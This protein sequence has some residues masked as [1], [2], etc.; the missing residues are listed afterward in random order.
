MLALT[1]EQQEASGAREVMAVNFVTVV[2][3][4]DKDAGTVLQTWRFADLPVTF[5]SD[6]YES[7]LI[8]VTPQTDSMVHL[9]RLESAGSDGVPGRTLRAVIHRGDIDGTLLYEDMRGQNLESASVEWFQV[10]VP[11]GGQGADVPPL[12]NIQSVQAAVAAMVIGDRVVR[13][14]GDFED[15][16]VTDKGIE[17]TA[18]AARPAIPWIIASDAT[19]VDP[20]DV[21]RRL[22]FVYGKMGKVR[23]VGWDVGAASTL[24]TLIDED[25]TTI[26]VTDG[27]RFPTSGSGLI[28]TESVSWTGR[29]A[30]SLTTVTRGAD[31]TTAVSHALGEV[32]VE[33]IATA[34]WIVNAR[35]SDAFGDLFVV[36]PYNGAVVRV[37]ASLYTSTLADTT[38]ISGETV[39]SVKFTA[40]NLRALLID[41]A[42]KGTLGEGALATE[43]RFPDAY[44]NTPAAQDHYSWLDG[45]IQTGRT[46]NTI[47]RRLRFEES[48]PRAD[49]V[50]EKCTYRFH[51]SL[52]NTATI[53]LRETSGGAVLETITNSFG[54]THQA[55]WEI[56]TTDAGLLG[57]ELWITTSVGTVTILAVSRIEHFAG[58]FPFEWVKPKA[59]AS[60]MGTFGHF[61]DGETAVGGVTTLTT[62]GSTRVFTI[63]YDTDTGDPPEEIR[64][65]VYAKLNAGTSTA[66]EVRI[67]GSGDAL[68]TWIGRS[69]N[70]GG[71]IEGFFE[72]VITSDNDSGELAS[73]VI[74]VQLQ[75]GNAGTSS[76]VTEVERW[77]LRPALTSSAE[78]A[79][80]TVGIGLVLFADLDGIVAAGGNYIAADGVVLE[81]MPDILRHV[82]ADLA[83]EGQTAISANW[84]DAASATNLDDN[85]HALVLNTLGASFEEIVERAAFDSRANIGVTHGSAATPLR[86]WEMLAAESD[87]TWDPPG[88]GAVSRTI[89][90]YRNV[91]EKLRP[92]FEV[93]TRFRALYNWDAS[94]GDG[95]EAFDS[96]VRIDTDQ[97]DTHGST[98]GPSN[99]EIATAETI[100][101]RRDAPAVLFPTIRDELTAEEVL[102][103]YAKERIREGVR[104]FS[105]F[106]V[107]WIEAYDLEQGDV[108]LLEVDWLDPVE[109]PNGARL[110]IV[111][112]D[113]DPSTN[114]FDVYG[115]EVS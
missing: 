21:G 84:D 46:S 63:T 103:Y 69:K 49:R 41:I 6:A 70:T 97:A 1:A 18:R 40:A 76:N 56:E 29:T 61:T 73:D 47:N 89:S 22:P 114:T 90:R 15:W 99:T 52:T 32:L 91:T 39:T 88:G 9:P 85:V 64:Y 101:G 75:N 19:Q 38:T 43:E 95:P 44:P 71:A 109:D 113:K 24:S 68:G 3:Y 81:K 8:D 10:L 57:S 33:T 74:Q 12:E 100:Y 77:E 50:I 17:I 36:S 51:A 94:R 53:Q 105:V 35:E 59:T 82:I 67:Q 87:Y 27:S 98:G 106:G 28:G 66:S 83:G 7:L 93:F 42:S 31:G 112:I 62:A 58:V 107:V 102:G 55:W 11:L 79:A 108:V 65:R 80:T 14:N 2:A 5:N 60:S 13:F 45:N 115:V 23:A 25:D 96:V 34:T 16:E 20:D 92:S 30:N 110:R 54:V 104:E 78:I 111:Q 48:G 72:T 86:I 26:V 37:D 4:S